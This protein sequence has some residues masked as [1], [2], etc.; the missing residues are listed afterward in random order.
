MLLDTL[1]ACL[2]ENLLKGIGEM[3]AGEGRTIADQC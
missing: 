2:L 1:G 3:R